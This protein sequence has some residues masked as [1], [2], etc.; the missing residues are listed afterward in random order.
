MPCCTCDTCVGGRCHDVVCDWPVG[1][2]AQTCTEPDMSYL[3]LNASLTS[4][5]QF[6]LICWPFAA[7]IAHVGF[8]SSVLTDVSNEGAG[9]GEGFAAN[10]TNTGLLSC[11]KKFCTI[12]SGVATIN[13]WQKFWMCFLFE[14]WGTC[15]NALVSLQSSRVTEGSLTVNTDVGFLP[16]VNTHMSLQIS[17]KIH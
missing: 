12:S 17:Y 9:L 7:A 14:D 4:F 5:I 10:C 6:F 1:L 3:Y 2:T 16:T 8:L 15:V 13:I 11:W